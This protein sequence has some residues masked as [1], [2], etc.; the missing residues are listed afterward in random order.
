MIA[1]MRLLRGLNNAAI[2]S[3]DATTARVDFWPVRTTKG[4]LGGAARGASQGGGARGGAELRLGGRQLGLVVGRRR[5][6]RGADRG[7]AR[8]R[9]AKRDGADASRQRAVLEHIRAHN[10]APRHQLRVGAAGGGGQDDLRARR[11]R[12]ASS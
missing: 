2:N 9:T 10:G 3:V 7:V 1:W 4:T 5:A 8:G 11:R 6:C 12:V